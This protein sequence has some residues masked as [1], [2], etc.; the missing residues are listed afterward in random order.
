MV[1]RRPALTGDLQQV[2]EAAGGDERR[3][4][5]PFLEEG[6]RADGHA[7]DEPPHGGG[8]RPGALE[9]GGDRRGDAGRLVAGR[10]G[11]LG[12][13]E[14]GAVEGDGVGERPADVDSEQ[15]AHRLSRYHSGKSAFAP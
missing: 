5:P 12:R 3:A 13:E 4:R 14:L 11:G 10:R 2:L 6:V 8:S 1:E 9:D 15:H 7:V